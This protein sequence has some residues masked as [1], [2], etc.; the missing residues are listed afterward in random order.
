MDLD[1]S[2]DE[3][4]TSSSKTALVSWKIESEESLRP[5]LIYNDYHNGIK[6]LSSIEDELDVCDSFF[7]SVAFITMSGLTCLLQKLADLKNSNVRGRIIT[8]DYLNFSDPKA[9]S[10]LLEFD[11]IDV[12]VYDKDN[13][14]TKGYVFNKGQLSTIIIG[15]SNI[16]QDA[17]ARN[18]E[19]NIRITSLDEGEFFKDTVADFEKM[20][21][22]SQILTVQWIE[23]YIPRHQAAVIARDSDIFSEDRHGVIVPNTMQKAALVNL[24]KLRCAGKNKALLISATGTG[25]TYLSAFDVKNFNSNK[26]LFLVHREQ[27]LNDAQKSFEKIMGSKITTGKVTGNQKEFDADI[28]FSTIQTMSK[29]ETLTRYSS[30]Y[31]DYIICDE[32]H[33]SFS[34]S[35]QKII[36]HFTP[37]FMLG[38]TATPERMDGGDVFALYDHNIA[39]E[40]RLQEAMEENMLCPFHYFGITD[41]TVNGRQINEKDKT[42]LNILTSDERIKHIVEKIKYYG[43]SGDRVKGIIF[44]SGVKESENLSKKLNYV[45]YKTLALSS[46]STQ[47]ERSKAVERLEQDS[48]ENCLDYVIAVDVLNEGID[49]PR[50]NQIVMLRPTESAI[51]FIQQLGRG[52]RKTRNKDFVVVIDFIGNYNNNFMIPIALSG[53]RSCNKD[54]IRRYVITGNSVVPGCSTIDFDKITKKKIFDSISKNNLSKMQNLKEGYMELKKRIGK[55]PSLVDL[56]KN[57]SLDP[58]VLI[59][60]SDNLNNFRTRIKEKSYAFLLNEIKTL[61]FIS[62]MFVNGKRPHELFILREIINFRI[63]HRQALF[64]KFESKYMI[65]DELSFESALSVL[66]GGFI[67]GSDMKKYKSYH[68]IEK[69]DDKIVCS[70]SFS[71]C[72]E[73]KE[74]VEMAE[75]AIECGLMIFDKEYFENFDGGLSLFK[76]YSRKDVCRLLNWDKDESS[77]IYGYRIKNNTC[78]IFVTYNKRNDISASTKYEDAFIDRQTFS[79]MTRSGVKLGSSEVDQIINFNRNGLKTYLFVKKDDGD[80][81]DFYYM[82]RVEPIIKSIA[83]KKNIENKSIVNIPFR[84]KSPVKNDIYNYLVS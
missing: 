68:L 17:L 15:S 47:D 79:W 16:T 81:T 31:F 76:K 46:L 73:N 71:K 50:V 38:M 40:I 7:F 78:P 55:S 54:N 82:G 51:V 63:I 25:K 13:F 72:L 69:V 59:D 24:S 23:N 2:I 18:K 64:S 67:S 70:N 39:Y 77:T 36:D 34:K 4:I 27:I 58:R 44:C 12:R 41:I 3:R 57:G 49:I 11:N 21:S 35:Y 14:H 26:T 6:V 65:R 52:L 61:D 45:G 8:T 37:K 9:L 33:H 60:Y 22:D 29:K 19:W 66:N 62:K 32:V 75:D 74:F 80:G 84:L 48:K 1:D 20:W 28:I 53:D 56:Y 42:N 43:H 5:R 83:E 30:D 10:K